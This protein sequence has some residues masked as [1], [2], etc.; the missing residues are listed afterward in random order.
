MEERLREVSVGNG[1]F[2]RGGGR[3]GDMSEERGAVVCEE[4]EVGAN[5]G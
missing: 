2:F 4:E 3:A 1:P 5:G